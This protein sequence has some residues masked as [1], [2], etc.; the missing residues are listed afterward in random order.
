MSI[1]KKQIKMWM[2]SHKI[3]QAKMFCWRSISK[4]DE[5]MPSFRLMHRIKAVDADVPVST[6]SLSSYFLGCHLLI[7]LCHTNCLEPWP[8]I[9]MPP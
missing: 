1:L 4:R 3:Y 2:S 7:Y 5:V 9:T 8:G 6:T